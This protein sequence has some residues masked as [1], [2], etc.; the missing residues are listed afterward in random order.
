[1]VL[2]F[3]VGMVLCFTIQ[4]PCTSLCHRR[5]AIS[6]V[7]GWKYNY[8]GYGG[9]SSYAKYSPLWLRGRARLSE[10]K[11]KDKGA[12]STEEPEEENK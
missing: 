2:L 12:P 9:F 11:Y 4:V 5:E 10:E 3:S 7:I 6:A 1:M 8:G